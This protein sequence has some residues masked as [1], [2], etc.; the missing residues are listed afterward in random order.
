MEFA[1][2]RRRIRPVVR[3]ADLDAE[4]AEGR[5]VLFRKWESVYSGW[6]DGAD[7]RDVELSYVAGEV[8]LVEGVE[9]RTCFLVDLFAGL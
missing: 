8:E 4:A 1:A 2:W 7:I 5:Y 9:K 6:V 3:G